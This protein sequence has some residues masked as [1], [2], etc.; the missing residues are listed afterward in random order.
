[1][2]TQ[3]S[4]FVWLP[5]FLTGIKT[6]CTVQVF[7]QIFDIIDRKGFGNTYYLSRYL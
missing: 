4:R 6:L 3:S 1:M 5:N 7:V 2:E